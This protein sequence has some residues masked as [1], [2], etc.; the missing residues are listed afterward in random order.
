MEIATGRVLATIADVPRPRVV[1]V[2]P[3]ASVELLDAAAA[4]LRYLGDATREALRQRAK[5]VR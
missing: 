3:P 1:R 5:F 2:D 4:L